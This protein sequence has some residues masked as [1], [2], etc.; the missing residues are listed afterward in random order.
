MEGGPLFAE[1]I[2]VPKS[3]RGGAQ[4]TPISSAFPIVQLS[5]PTLAYCAGFCRYPSEAIRGKILP[6]V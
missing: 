3:L 6:D 1:W 5:W 4:T 2:Q